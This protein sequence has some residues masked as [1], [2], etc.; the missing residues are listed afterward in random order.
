MNVEYSLGINRKVLQSQHG[1]EE[2]MEWLQRDLSQL[3][4]FVWYSDHSLETQSR[5]KYKALLG[6]TYN[7]STYIKGLILPNIDT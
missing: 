1:N 4:A 3:L 7:L 5:D 6:I 2:Q